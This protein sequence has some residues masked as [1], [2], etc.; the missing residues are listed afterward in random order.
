M[1]KQNDFNCFIDTEVSNRDANVYRYGREDVVI[2]YKL[3]ST[4]SFSMNGFIIKMTRL[5]FKIRPDENIIQA[6]LK[7]RKGDKTVDLKVDIV[8][9]KEDNTYRLSDSS[10][11][12]L[13]R[14]IYDKVNI[15]NELIS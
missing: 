1:N 14:T 4:N 3:F 2:V 5:C 10:Y 6:I 12:E 13:I 7:I 11:M 8:L 9:K 15:V